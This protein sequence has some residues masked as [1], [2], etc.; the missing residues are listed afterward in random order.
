[1]KKPVFGIVLALSALLAAA[2][3]TI[4]LPVAITGN[5]VG[6]KTGESAAAAVI[7]SC[8]VYGSGSIGYADAAANGGITRIAT[9]EKRVRRTPFRVIT[10]IIVNG[11]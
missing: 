10:T 9:I 2:C 3:S 4:T 1:M 8:F 7:T 6:D 5:P 11:S